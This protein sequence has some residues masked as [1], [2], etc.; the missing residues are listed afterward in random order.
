MRIRFLFLA[1]LISSQLLLAQSAGNTG[2]AFLKLG[3]G[4]RNIALGD[5]GMTMANDATSIFYNPANLALNQNQEIFV[6]HNQWL[7]DASS[8]MLGVK[9]NL[10]GLPIGIGINAT[11]IRGFEI[12]TQATT[13]KDGSFDVHYFSGA[14]STG[15][16]ITDQIMAGLA[17]KYLYEGIYVDESDGLAVDLGVRYND[18]F[19]DFS[20]ACA[21][22]NIG[23]MTK[24]KNDKTV[25]PTEFKLGGSYVL[26]GYFPKFDFNAG[27][28]FQKYLKD[29]N[30]HLNFG[31][32]TLYDKM[33]SIRLG[34]MT[35]YEAKGFSAGIGILWRSVAFDYAFTPYSYDLGNGHTFSLKIGL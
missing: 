32:E 14:V 13:E 3:S 12:R 28:E 10:L 16:S 19:P 24:L 11:T 5:N 27:V 1:T 9:F 2:M 8:E 17:V 33:F 22:K 18:I 29:D 25:L 34:Y 15:F 7:Q 30:E 23:S 6:A 26:P 31:L 4:A 20:M 21:M 35:N